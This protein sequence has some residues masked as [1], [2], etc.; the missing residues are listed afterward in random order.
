MLVS[1]DEVPSAEEAEKLANIA[2]PEPAEATGRDTPEDDVSLM[3][4]HR[5]FPHRGRCVR[6]IIFRMLFKVEGMH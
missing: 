1:H 4:N 5:S 6:A 3:C 2:A